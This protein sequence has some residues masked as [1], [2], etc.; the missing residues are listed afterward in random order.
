MDSTPFRRRWKTSIQRRYPA[1]VVLTLIH[2]RCIQWRRQ[3]ED[4]RGRLSPSYF[5]NRFWDFSNSEVKSVGGRA[6]ILYGWKNFQCLAFKLSIN[7]PENALNSVLETLEIKKF[8]GEHALKPLGISRLRRSFFLYPVSSLWRRYWLYRR[9][10]SNVDSICVFESFSTSV[11]TLIRRS[12]NAVLL[13]GYIRFWKEN[14]NWI[15]C[16]A[17]NKL[18]QNL[19]CSTLKIKMRCYSCV[20]LDQLLIL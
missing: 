17:Y 19:Q 12:I 1:N 10:K 18:M 7:L 11:A 2:R 9:R 13:L 8:L 20:G 3:G 15:S 6:I 16:I 4:W 14:H 5:N